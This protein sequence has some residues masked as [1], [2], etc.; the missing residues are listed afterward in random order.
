MRERPFT[1]NPSPPLHSLTSLSCHLHQ[2]PQIQPR[3]QK[4]HRRTDCVRSNNTPP[5]PNKPHLEVE[6][7][8]DRKERREDER[9][10]KAAPVTET[11]AVAMP[12]GG[13]IAI[14]ATRHPVVYIATPSVPPAA[15]IMAFSARIVSDIESCITEAGTPTPKMSLVIALSNLKP[16]NLNVRYVSLLKRSQFSMTA[17]VIPSDTIVAYAA[18]AIP[19][20][21]VYMKMGSSTMFRPAAHAQAV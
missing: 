12:I 1:S 20:S 9:A 8:E 16:L 13:R 17:D 15:T 14:D 11:T 2:T 7:E 18:P 10:P 19:I 21:K 5:D 3:P 6:S 4:C